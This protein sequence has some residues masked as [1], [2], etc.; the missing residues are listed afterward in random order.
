MLSLEQYRRL[1]ER[2][3][4][5]AADVIDRHGEHLACHKGCDTCCTHFGISTVEALALALEVSRLPRESFRAL[6]RQPPHPTSGEACPL[7][8]EGACRLYLA[9][10]LICR[11]QGLPLLIREGDTQRVDCCPLNFNGVESLPGDAV[12]D[13][14][15]LNQTLAAINLLCLRELREQGLELP[16]RYLLAEALQLEFAEGG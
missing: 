3:D 5:F 1:V 16:E 14:E 9:R 12:L 8:L 2:I 13:L 6:R 10:P 7:L 4:R 15:T 11:T